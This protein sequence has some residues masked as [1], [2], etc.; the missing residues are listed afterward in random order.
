MSNPDPSPAETDP[1]FP[2]GKWA[3]YFLQ[4][5]HPGR[6]M[7]E[8]ELTF[9][10]GSLTGAGRDWVGRFIVRGRYSTDDGN[11]YWTKR[12]LGQH[13]VFYQGYNEGKGIWGRW[14]IG[15]SD[16]GGFHIWPEG[17]HAAAGA[18]LHAE[19]DVPVEA[20]VIPAE[21]VVTDAPA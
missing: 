9:R 15:A 3:G 12:Y 1:R 8:L 20:E 10:N 7:M 11:C 18:D 13:D 6:S 14:E 21:E 5:T 16:H 2:S 17:L 19:A 4:R